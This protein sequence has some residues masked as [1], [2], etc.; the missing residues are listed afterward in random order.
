[1][2]VGCHGTGT[3][4]RKGKHAEAIW[5]ELDQINDMGTVTHVETIGY[6]ATGILLAYSVK[7]THPDERTYV[8]HV[9][10]FHNKHKV[11]VWDNEV[12]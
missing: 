10:F 3:L 8:G 7:L 9:A 11:I 2:K 5:K 6:Y 4:L 1:M 12:Q